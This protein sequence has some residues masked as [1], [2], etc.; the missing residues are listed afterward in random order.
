MCLCVC[1]S[2][3]YLGELPAT[4]LPKWKEVWLSNQEHGLW[5]RGDFLPARLC[6]RFLVCRW[7]WG[8]LL[9][10]D[11]MKM[12]CHGV[13]EGLG[14]ETGPWAAVGNICCEYLCWLFTP[15]QSLLTGSRRTDVRSHFL[16]QTRSPKGRSSVN[17]SA[18]LTNSSTT[19]FPPTNVAL[20]W[21]QRFHS[22]SAQP[23]TASPRPQR[24]GPRGSAPGPRTPPAS[25]REAPHPAGCHPHRRHSC[26]RAAPTNPEVLLQSGGSRAFPRTLPGQAVPAGKGFGAALVS[27][28][29]VGVAPG[30]GR[31]RCW[32]NRGLGWS[33]R[34]GVDCIPR[35]CFEG[36]AWAAWVR[37]SEV[38]STTTTRQA[39][40][41]R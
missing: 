30:R 9:D 25:S 8:Y 12:K 22:L 18:K 35:V 34:G 15:L 19:I 32:G 39:L 27:E 3:H 24:Q 37:P 4:Q 38:C 31:G 28:V 1:T 6:L 40:P 5:S 2:P 13:C 7:G 14:T 36:V 21:P 17:A 10:R 41:R 23:Q 20:Q 29:S 11:P 16:P 26:R 33:V